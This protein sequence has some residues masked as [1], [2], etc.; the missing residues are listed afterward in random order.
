MPAAG[1]LKGLGKFSLIAYGVTSIFHR[2]PEVPFVE[3]PVLS[4]DNDIEPMASLWI[5]LG[6]EEWAGRY[7]SATHLLSTLSKPR[8]LRKKD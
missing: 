3:Q 5:Y 7:A 2:Q 8:N 1:S 4:A 6:S